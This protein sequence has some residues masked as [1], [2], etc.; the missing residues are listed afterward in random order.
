MEWLSVVI[1]DKFLDN[2]TDEV[3]KLIIGIG[4]MMCF[5]FVFAHDIVKNG[6]QDLKLLSEIVKGAF[7]I[8]FER[9]T[10]HI[11]NM[12]CNLNENTST[13]NKLNSVILN[14]D[15]ETIVKSMNELFRDIEL[16]LRD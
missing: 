1:R 12:A 10:I 3:V 11:I 14:L 9:L 6:L 8:I 16:K 15:L 2:M 13:A 5:N 4:S 7:P